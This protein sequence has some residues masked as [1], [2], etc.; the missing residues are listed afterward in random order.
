MLHAKQCETTGIMGKH[1]LRGG[2]SANMPYV[3][4][5]INLT[6]LTLKIL[7]GIVLWFAS[8][9][10]WST[11]YRDFSLSLYVRMSFFVFVFVVLFTAPHYAD[12]LSDR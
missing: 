1:R 4:F 10:C 5:V 2:S 12:R 8:L 7:I 3:A 11:H 9:L 6:Y